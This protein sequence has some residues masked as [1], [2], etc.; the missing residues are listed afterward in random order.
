[1]QYNIV[2]EIAPSD[3]E[4]RKRQIMELVKAHQKQTDCDH[5]GEEW[6]RCDD[7]ELLRMLNYKISQA[8]KMFEEAI[9]EVV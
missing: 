9:I 8:E 2:I 7:L 1:M 5:K 4:K 6:Y 3:F